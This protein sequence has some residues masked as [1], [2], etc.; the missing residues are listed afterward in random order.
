MYNNGVMVINTCITIKLDYGDE[1][2]F[3]N[4]FML[5]DNSVEYVGQ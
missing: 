5:S 1:N 3:N 4:G 2:M